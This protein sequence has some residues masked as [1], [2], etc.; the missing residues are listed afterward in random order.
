MGLRRLPQA[1]CLRGV[2][3]SMMLTPLAYAEEKEPPAT[4]DVP[5][6]ALDK[7][8]NLEKDVDNNPFGL[9][10]H[11]PNYVLPITYNDSPNQKPFEDEAH[12]ID[13]M[14]MKFQ[15]SLKVL[16][17]KQ[18]FDRYSFLNFGYTNQSYFQIYNRELSAPFRETNHEPEVMLNYLRPFDIGPAKIKVNTLGLSHQSN[19]QTTERSRSWNRVYLQMVG[20]V[21]GTYFSFKP[22]Y[23][24]P[25]SKKSDPEDPTGDDNPDIEFYMGHFELQLLQQR[26]QDTIGIIWRNN[27]RSENRGAV[28][29]DWTFPIGKR[30]EGYVQ[31]FNGYGESLLDYN[32]S[33]TR[34]G[35]GIMLTN[36][37]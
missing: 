7:R 20:E 9:V 12:G 10:P 28:Q 32:D 23:R 3:L 14:E 18:V 1:G 37:L 31:F 2:M 26:G 17:V 6:S 16:M 33:T 30:L 34:L 4:G 21:D 15:L 13:E 5:I 35:F 11:K 25:E 27:L 19:G 24:L 36:W 29:I 8:L 22:W